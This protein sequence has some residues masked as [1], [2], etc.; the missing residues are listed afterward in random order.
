M[1]MFILV[2]LYLLARLT[3]VLFLSRVYFQLARD[4]L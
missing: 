2:S 1:C 4:V 3:Y